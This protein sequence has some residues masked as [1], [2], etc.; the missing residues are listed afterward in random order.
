[1]TQ[2]ISGYDYNPG[3]KLQIAILIG[4]L[5]YMRDALLSSNIPGACWVSG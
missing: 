2:V 5:E 3:F 4:W 1:M